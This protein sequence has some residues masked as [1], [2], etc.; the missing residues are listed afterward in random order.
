[1]RKNAMALFGLFLMMIAAA[2]RVILFLRLHRPS[3]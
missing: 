1:M 3:R 2:G